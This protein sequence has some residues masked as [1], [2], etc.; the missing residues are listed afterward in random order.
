MRTLFGV[1]A[2]AAIGGAVGFSQLLCPSGSCALTGS[3]YGGALFG[4]LLAAAFLTSL[5][6]Q[7]KAET[8]ERPDAE[9]ETRDAR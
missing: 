4:G 6:G 2:G 8:R 7:T 5:P 3:W 1:V 9:R